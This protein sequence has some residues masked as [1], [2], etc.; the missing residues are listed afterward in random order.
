MFLYFKNT[1]TVPECEKKPGKTPR[2]PGKNQ[3]TTGNRQNYE[4]DNPK[5]SVLIMA[6][7]RVPV[8]CEAI[9]TVILGPFFSTRSCYCRATL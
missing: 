5:L 3:K 7:V 6:Q 9:L 2:K 4:E 1:Y 8:V